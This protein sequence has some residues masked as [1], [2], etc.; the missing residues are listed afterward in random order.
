MEAIFPIRLPLGG[1]LDLNLGRK[2]CCQPADNM[3][4]DFEDWRIA[5]PNWQAPVLYLGQGGSPASVAHAKLAQECLAGGGKP[6]AL[7]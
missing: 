7:I 6:P 5:G 1:E 2:S 3:G 4:D